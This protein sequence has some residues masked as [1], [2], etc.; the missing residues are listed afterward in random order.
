MVQWRWGKAV[1]VRR[2]GLK[3]NEPGKKKQPQIKRAKYKSEIFLA[4]FRW[5]PSSRDPAFSPVRNAY[6]VCCALRFYL[7]K[8][9]KSFTYNL[10]E[11]GAAAMSVL[12]L[13]STTDLLIWLRRLT[14]ASLCHPRL[15]HK[16]TSIRSG[17]NC[18]EVKGMNKA[19]ILH[20]ENIKLNDPKHESQHVMTWGKQWKLPGFECLHNGQYPVL[21]IFQI[22]QEYW[23]GLFLISLFLMS[24]YTFKWR[25]LLV[26][27]PPSCSN[28]SYVLLFFLTIAS[29]TY[30][31]HDIQFI[32]LV[33]NSVV[34]G[35]F[36]EL[37][38]RH[39]NL[40]LEHF[41]HPNKN[42]ST[43]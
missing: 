40:V 42:H 15:S 9:R 37:H 31:S 7:K 30:N 1:K 14:A 26:I 34:F 12:S 17:G 20:Q 27:F 16:Y 38:N 36:T 21:I 33:Y 10:L 3:D 5:E 28:I 8:K 22:T 13:I 29:L 41:N 4:S 24:L 23:V 39:D 19:L 6:G 18:F 11:C 35:M 25:G 43:H 32:H 2:K